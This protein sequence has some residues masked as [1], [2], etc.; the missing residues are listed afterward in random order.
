MARLAHAQVLLACA[1]IG[2]GAVTLGIRSADESTDSVAPVPAESPPLDPSPEA[3]A[4]C[5]AETVAAWK[6]SLHAA[7]WTDPVFRAEYD[8]APAASCRECHDPP[9][10][11]PG[12]HAIDCATCHVQAGRILATSS[13]A[14]ARAAHP[15]EIDP[16]LAQVDRCGKCHQ[17]NYTDDGIHD[18]G[19]AL[20]DTVEEWRRSESSARDRTCVDCHMP[21]DR[22]HRFPG[23]ADP[24]LMST[25]IDLEFE[26]KRSEAGIDVTLRARGRHIG[27]AF[28]TGDV[29]RR[30]VL[31][32]RS[33][34][35]EDRVIMQRWLARTADADGE[36]SHVR[37]VDDTRVPPPGSGELVHTL[38]IADPSARELEWTLELH[39]LPLARARQRG[40]P[41]ATTIVKVRSDTLRVAD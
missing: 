16:G 19:E 25:A 3:C 24:Q 9:T 13:S 29:F 18:P 5:H 35:A 6:T 30:A 23:M 27:H 22:S 41:D 14:E 36:D 39:R 17:F 28:P 21:G 11:A 34:Q 37:T 31:T 2:V 1:L 32:V 38:H 26:T 8:P 40:L 10:A 7:S 33:D 20:Q 12:E 15:I 4:E